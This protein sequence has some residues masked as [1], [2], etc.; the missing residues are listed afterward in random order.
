MK[1]EVKTL[2]ENIGIDYE[3]ELETWGWFL[4][5]CSEVPLPDEWAKERTP[6]NMIVYYNINTRI[7]HIVHPFI[8]RF[9]QTFYN[10]LEKID[11]WEEEKAKIK[12][13]MM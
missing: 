13:D 3:K 5:D 11:S 9:R 2:A 8:N 12:K 4:I 10:L 1:N 6:E 7:S